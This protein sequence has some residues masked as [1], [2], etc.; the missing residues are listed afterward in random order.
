[1]T[2]NFGL[3]SIN[4]TV[5]KAKAPPRDFQKFFHGTAINAVGRRQVREKKYV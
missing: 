3:G 2:D 1:M 5:R 4:S